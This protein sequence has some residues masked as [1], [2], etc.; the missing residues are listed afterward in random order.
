MYKSL[1]TQSFPKI[2]CVGKNYLKHVNE[3]G[4]TSVPT[5]PVIFEKSW[6]SLSYNP[7]ILCLPRTK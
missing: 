1:I 3:M 7:K 4:G 6:T 5:S 2:L